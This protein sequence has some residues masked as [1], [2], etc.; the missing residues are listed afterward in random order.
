MNCLTWKSHARASSLKRL[1]GNVTTEGL[2]LVST[3]E[4]PKGEPFRVVARA[5]GRAGATVAQTSKSAVS[6]V[7]QPAN[8]RTSPGALSFTLIPSRGIGRMKLNINAF[9]PPAD[10]WAVRKFK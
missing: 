7:S 10:R 5:L 3:K 6:Q 4:D 1:N 8:A 2:W 9:M